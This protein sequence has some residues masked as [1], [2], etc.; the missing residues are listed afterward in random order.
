VL[1]HWLEIWEILL[2]LC[3]CTRRCWILLSTA[4]LFGTSKDVVD[5]VHM[6]TSLRVSVFTTAPF[7][8]SK[9]V[10]DSVHYVRVSVGLAFCFKRTLTL[11]LN[12]SVGE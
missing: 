5:F 3:V 9:D 7:C 1:R 2:V 4:T 6:Y 11:T 8:I 10:I 12:R